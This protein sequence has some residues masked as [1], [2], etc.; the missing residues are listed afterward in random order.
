M[1]IDAQKYNLLRMA[2]VDNPEQEHDVIEVKP[3]KFALKKEHDERVLAAAMELLEDERIVDGITPFDTIKTFEDP[4][5]EVALYVLMCYAVALQQGCTHP[6]SLIR[7]AYNIA[8]WVFLLPF[9]FSGIDYGTGFI[10]FTAII[11]IRLLLN[12]YINNVLDLT[13]EQYQL[14]PFRI[15]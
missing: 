13:P 5:P 6:M 15:P 14:Y 12:L 8:F 9:L 11:I 4:T 2:L 1:I 7:T 3:K 10:A